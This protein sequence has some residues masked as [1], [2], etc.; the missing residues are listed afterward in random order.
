VHKNKPSNKPR[1]KCKPKG[2]LQHPCNN[3][4]HTIEVKRVGVRG[5]MLNAIKYDQKEQQGVRLNM[6][7]CEEEQ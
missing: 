4:K 6:N 1:L 7:K 3:F 2:K 5:L